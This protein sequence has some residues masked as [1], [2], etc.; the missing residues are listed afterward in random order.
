M[1]KNEDVLPEESKQ[2][3]F[4]LTDTFPVVINSP[5]G[6]GITLEFRNTDTVQSVKEAISEKL[7]FEI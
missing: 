5:S 3:E 4:N 6:L 7:G 2:E 1:C